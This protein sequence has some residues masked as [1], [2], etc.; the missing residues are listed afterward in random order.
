MD[1]AS[2]P[3]G[4]AVAPAEAGASSANGAAAPPAAEDGAAV[5]DPNVERGLAASVRVFDFCK[6]RL[7]TLTEGT[8]EAPTSGHC[9]FCGVSVAVGLGANTMRCEGC[10]DLYHAKC[11]TNAQAARFKGLGWH[12][13]KCVRPR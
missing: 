5:V 9:A 1:G 8:E 6:Q 11:L 7:L 13:D 4:P 2:A 12:C 10:G 3:S